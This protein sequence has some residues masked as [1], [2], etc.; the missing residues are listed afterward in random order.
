MWK[1]MLKLQHIMYQTQPRVKWTKCQCIKLL[2]CSGSE[3]RID[4]NGDATKWQTFLPTNWIQ[5][6][7]HASQTDLRTRLQKKLFSSSSQKMLQSKLECFSLPSFFGLVR[8]VAM[9]TVGLQVRVGPCLYFSL[10]KIL[11]M[12]KHSSLLRRAVPAKYFQT[13]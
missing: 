11:A 4:D 10:L 12:H 3:Q 1:L 6:I 9:P 8:L 2:T 5:M 7:V 13:G